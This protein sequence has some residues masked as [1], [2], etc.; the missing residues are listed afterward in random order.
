MFWAAFTCGPDTVRSYVLCS[1]AVAVVSN[2]ATSVSSSDWAVIRDCCTP[3]AN[4][5]WLNALYSSARC[6]A[7]WSLAR[8][9]ESS[10]WTSLTRMESEVPCAI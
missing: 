7:A 5:C 1:A 10:V 6:W 9:S 8:A 2:A 3:S 4:S